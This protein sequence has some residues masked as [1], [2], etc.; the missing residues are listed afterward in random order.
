MHIRT[1]WTQ[2]PIFIARRNVNASYVEYMVRKPQ[3]WACL[4]ADANSIVHD[5]FSLTARF[6]SS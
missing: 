3:L 4:S 1:E 2:V 6:G 5:I